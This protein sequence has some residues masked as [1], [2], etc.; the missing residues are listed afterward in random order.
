MEN[1]LV[2]TVP[3]K[4]NIVTQLW[5]MYFPYWPVFI[6]LL[7]LSISGAWFYLSRKTPLYESTATLL[8][9]DE[10]KGIDD[11]RMIESLNL[12]STKKIVE[13]EIEVLSS[14]SLMNEVVSNL[15]LYAP[16]YTEGRW[17]GTP[18]YSSSP[19]KVEVQDPASITPVD[20]ILF[21]YDPKNLKVKIANR[22]YPL[23]E[24]VN[25]PYGSLKFIPAKTPVTTS[26]EGLYFSLLN[27]KM[28][29]LNLM[30]SLE[31]SASSKLSTVIDLKLKAE[32][33]KMAEDILNELIKA[34]NRA[35][36]NDKNAL[37]ANTLE[38][39]QERLNFVGKHLD[40]IEHRIEEYKAK[41]GAVDI[42][43]QGKLFLQNVSENDQKLSDINMQLAVLDQVEKYVQAKDN[44]GG[45]VPATLGISDPLLTQLLGKLYDAEL[46][47]EKLKKTTGENSPVMLAVTD[48]IEKIK[49][50][51]LENIRSQRK[52]LEASRSNLASTNSSYSSMLQSIPEKERDLV[53]ISRQHN[54]ESSIYSFLLQKREEAAL[55]NSSTVADNRIVDKAESSLF[56]VSPS[57][58]LIYI[59]AV[60]LAIGLGVAL[61]TG[62][63][64]L[65]K[66]ILY[67][68]EIEAMTSMPIIGEIG[69]DKMKDPIVIRDGAH[70]LLAEQFRKLRTSLGFIG[71]GYKRR[72]LLI[73][74]SVPGEGKSFITANLALSLALTGK[75]IVVI[76]A[77]MSNPSVSEKLL[78]N[79]EKGL[80]SFLCGELEPEEIIRRTELNKN[81]FVI[82]AGAL[83]PN[84]SELI[85]SGRMEELLVYLENIFD[86]V[87]ID[88]AP[89]GALSDAYV[90][91]PLCDA[92]LYVV[93]HGHT[94]KVAVE[95]LDKNNKVNE[96]KNAGIVFNGVKTRGFSKD[97]YGNGYGYGYV[98][99]RNNKRR[100]K[101]LAGS[102][103]G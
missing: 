31:A 10:K 50:S 39:V 21:S 97:S 48:Q 19:V 34:Y 26:K 2:N 47:K 89:V 92:T 28:V 80:S 5:N 94:P 6:V 81:L 9:K 85:M 86:H 46:Q 91:A 54:I 14:R 44:N 71:I 101:K 22:A 90:L 72:K 76:E 70:N 18:A 23:N 55:S 11:S 32:D 65:N 60:L 27:S 56:P 49:P 78:V 83:P 17:R 93:R 58:K 41:K 96:L 57:K 68:A 24:W 38:F 52:S 37:A 3:T 1:I 77:D 42:S 29:T 12:I 33:P 61:V 43:S 59:A 8:I 98:Y 15:K 73:T 69:Y 103:R 62:K 100:K 30:K 102:E 51:I 53:E 95:R 88:T 84:P 64:F 25:T 99:D 74:S 66:N 36:V 75:K 35:A 7:I 40:S 4:K 79:E 67:R 16:V 87:L 45:I 13:N 63:E 82:P 20:K